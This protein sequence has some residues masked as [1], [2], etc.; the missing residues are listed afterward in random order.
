M[1]TET[2]E[3][4]ISSLRQG[5]GSIDAPL[6]TP[7]KIT[8]NIYGMYTSAHPQKALSSLTLTARSLADTQLACC[9]ILTYETASRLNTPEIFNRYRSSIGEELL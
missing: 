3:V 7:A 2:I 5:T 4:E 6:T 8:K 9:S 1:S